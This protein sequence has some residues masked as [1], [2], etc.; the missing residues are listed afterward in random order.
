MRA[1]LPARSGHARSASAGLASRWRRSG[2]PCHSRAA[3]SSS[4]L[5][6]PSP[7]ASSRANRVS[8]PAWNSCR[9]ISPCHPR[10]SASA[11]SCHGRAAR[12]GLA[13]G[14]L[15]SGR[16]RDE[17]G[18][19]QRE[20][21]PGENLRL[22]GSSPVVR[23]P[24]RRPSPACMQVRRPRWSE[25]GHNVE[26]AWRL[27]GSGLETVAD[28]VHRLHQLAPGGGRRQLAAQ[29]LDVAVDGAVGHDPVIVVEV[30]EQLRAREHPARMRCQRLEQP[31]LDRVSNP[32]SR[33]PAR[34]GRIP[35]R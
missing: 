30:L 16:P 25:H 31:E 5:S 8:P 24:R 1:N 26:E 33:R 32:A 10:R 27:P 12:F 34:P 9:L 7:S 14:R 6:R 29:V 11:A 2:C 20:Q 13:R 15:C 17:C 21:A 3:A 35:A 22:H 18:C 4:G 19:S 23:V 28:P